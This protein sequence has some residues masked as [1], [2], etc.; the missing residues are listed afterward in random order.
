MNRA[1][2]A[3]V[4]CVSA[5]AKVW[6]DKP[7]NP[8]AGLRAAQQAL[9]A[10]DFA[11]AYD[12]YA[13]LAEE[14]PL[15][16]F[17]LGLFHREGWGRPVDQAAAC[18]WFE[19]AAV[20]GVPAAQH[21]LGDCLA[22][23]IHRPADIPAALAWYDK[24][25][26]AG[27]LISLCAAADYYIRGEGVRKDPDHGLALCAQAAQSNSPPA[28]LR[29]AG[30]YRTG[31]AGKPDLPAARYWY[32]KAAEQRVPEAQYRLGVMLAEGQGGKPDP[33]QGLYWLELAAGAG[34]APAYRPTAI[35]YALAQPQTDTQAAE[36]RS[37]LYFWL[38]AAKAT[39]DNPARLAEI[40]RMEAMLASSIPADRRA[41]LDKQVAEQLAKNPGERASPGLP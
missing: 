29:L 23:G 36:F 10:G 39:D 37:K 3:L 30:Y 13:R 1:L 25:A 14:N 27:D 28:M 41:A 33:A 2:L 38:S 22:A 20:N 7:V 35:L 17:S 26:A 40:G 31:A 32:S 34:H 5:T 6:A 15:A 11:S 4:L 16:Q 12:E 24:A 21:F 9:N 19:K 18:R 8:A